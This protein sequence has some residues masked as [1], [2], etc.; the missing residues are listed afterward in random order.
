MNRNTLKAVWWAGAVVAGGALLSAYAH[1]ATLGMQSS[2]QEDGAA[3]ALQ[4]QGAWREKL[5][6]P[7]L[8][9]RERAYE[10]LLDAARVDRDGRKRLEQWGKDDRHLEFAWTCRLALRELERER[11][12]WSSLHL[13]QPFEF[14]SDLFEK[15]RSGGLFPDPG[16]GWLDSR[17]LQP[18]SGT[19]G[20]VEQRSENFSLQISPDG[21]KCTVK[22]QVD[23]KE[24][25]QEYEAA[26]LEDLLQAHPELKDRVNVGGF[27][28]GLGFQNG[29]GGFLLGPR[30]PL[31][32]PDTT[33]WPFDFGSGPGPLNFGD[34][35]IQGNRTVRTDVLGVYARA[36]RDTDANK[37][38]VEPGVGLYV[39]GI[40]PG[41]IA[42][43]LGL[44]VGDVLL[45]LNG[46][47]LKSRDD[48]S[49]GLAAREPAGELSVVI[50][51][52]KGER[53]TRTWKPE[54]RPASESLKLPGDGS[55]RKL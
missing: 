42:A 41:T 30:G 5:A 53:Q 46:K 7:D 18:G 24:E 10:R 49:S 25:V 38:S 44:K 13:G 45:E 47:P 2:K 1:P 3:A 35:G 14:D 51:D 54:E 9:E 34:L 22:R 29:S 15:L 43:R 4:D 6:S 36:L 17:N 31:T 20:S 48:I 33:L 8:A 40:A 21:V 39:E 19:Q 27:G 11:G 23:G 50:L 55:L 37:S 26:T 12:S 16:Q 32:V 28:G 52:G